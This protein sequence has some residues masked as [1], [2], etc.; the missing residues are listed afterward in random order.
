[1]IPSGFFSRVFD[2]NWGRVAVVEYAYAYF[3]DWE[4]AA[5]EATERNAAG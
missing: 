2:A 3:A 4:R 5:R 1:M